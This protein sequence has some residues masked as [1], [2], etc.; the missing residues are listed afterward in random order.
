MDHVRVMKRQPHTR[1]EAIAAT[2]ALRIL[3]A[4]A[5]A[6]TCEGAPR[7]LYQHTEGSNE[8]CNLILQKLQQAQ[9]SVNETSWRSISVAA[10]YIRGCATAHRIRDGMDLTAG[11]ASVEDGSTI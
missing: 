7:R 10:Q 11:G 2:R 4:N 9:R 8:T 3:A 5:A 6:T 1:Q